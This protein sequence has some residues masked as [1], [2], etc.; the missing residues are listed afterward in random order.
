M[1]VAHGGS[2]MHRRF[3]RVMV[4]ASGLTM[5][6]VCASAVG[7]DPTVQSAPTD[8]PASGDLRVW[9]VDGATSRAD[10]Q[11]LAL[12][13]IPIRG[14]FTNLAGLVS[15]GHSL[16]AVR[17]MVP[18]AGLKM[19]S[20]DKRRWALSDEFFDAERFPEIEFEATLAPEASLSA[21]QVGQRIAGNLTM[22]GRI[23]SQDFRLTRSNC[24]LT[25]PKACE[26][27]LEADIRRSRFGLDRH[28][29]TLAD[30]VSMK[31]TLHLEPL[32]P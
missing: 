9:R 2:L 26:L 6:L 10:F 25:V 28:S 8:H 3:A 13:M 18:M 32:A 5:M 20:P 17:V 12:A 1:R 24:D 27:D 21:L 7:E 4:L 31:I 16:D 15:R 30:T 22:H 14:Q 29:F 19:R 11:V 23:A